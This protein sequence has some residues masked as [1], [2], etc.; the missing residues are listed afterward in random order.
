MSLIYRKLLLALSLLLF[1][2]ISPLVVLYALGY[3]LNGTAANPLPVGVLIAESVPTRAVVEINGQSYGKTPQSVANLSPGM[4]DLTVSKEGYVAWHKHLNIH[5]GQVTEARDIRLFPAAPSFK[6]LHSNMQTFSLSPSRQLIASITEDQQLHVNDEDGIAVISPLTFSRL[7]DRILWS[8]DSSSLLLVSAGQVSFVNLTDQL[9]QPVRLPQLDQAHQLAWDQRIPGRLY[10]VTSKHDLIAY[11]ISNQ[12][13]LLIA[14]RI[15]S[16][17][18]SSR[19]L[20]L[21]DQDNQLQIRNLQGGMIES[22]L[23]K[24]DKIIQQLHVTPGGHI[25]LHFTDRSA[26]VLTDVGTLLPVSAAV[27]R[28]GWSPDEQ[29][30]FVQTDDTSLYVMNIYDER[31]SYIPMY[32]LHLVT[33][34]SRPIRSPQWFAGGRH[35]IYQVDDE[36]MIT[37][38]D[39]RDQPLTYTVD[40]TNLGDANI[41]VGTQGTVVLYLKKTAQS[42]RL[43]QARLTTAVDN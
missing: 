7:P 35:L 39:T 40:T 43:V 16:F 3:R 19:Q 18:T 27:I 23:L 29:M 9:V 2:C 31:A 32:S 12:S 42:N 5:S 11:S 34:L 8:P 1:I 41:T 25:A 10:A 24:T 4:I 13:S 21:I 14:P 20:F 37:E 26:A 6:T 36:I 30:L 22:P 38:I 15:S 33:R 17:V 28:L